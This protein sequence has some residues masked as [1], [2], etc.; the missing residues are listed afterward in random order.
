MNKV[1]VII[2]LTILGLSSL[3]FADETMTITT[4]YPSPYGSYRELTAHRMKI[5][6]IYSLPGTSVA[7][8]NLIVEGRVGINTTNLEGILNVG[9]L[10]VNNNGNDASLRVVKQ[11]DAN[12][13]TFFY[14][15]FFENQ[16]NSYFNAGVYAS[17]RGTCSGA[18]ACWAVHGDASGGVEDNYGVGVF[19]IGDL[20]PGVRAQSFRGNAIEAVGGNVIINPGNVGIGNITPGAKLVVAGGVRANKG[21]TGANDLSNV[22]YSFEQ[23]GDTGM[24]C[25]GGNAIML[26]DLIFKTDTVERMRIANSGGYVGIGTSS[27]TER[28]T[29]A[30]NVRISGT[31]ASNQ[32]VD[33]AENMAW[34]DKIQR[35]PEPG[36]VVV[37]DLQK[38]ENITLTDEPYNS[39]VAGVISTQPG[40]LL[41][42]SLKGGAV[43]LIGRVPTKVNNDN[44]AI[45]RGSLL[46]T[47]SKPGYAMRGDPEKI[48]PGM[49]IGKAMG[50]LKETDAEG[51]IPVLVN[52]N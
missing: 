4:Y 29:V 6:R 28:L 39:S 48:K 3:G 45:N 38:D 43:A 44:G 8:D 22:G 40:L 16:D 5:G 19:G 33:I 31:Y 41:G 25:V 46:V 36:D 47:S 14:T 52:S 49:L 17:Y 32:A 18:Q 34:T 35:P 2:G 26:S 23:D 27:P 50:E 12:S 10:P 15:G 20:G 42:A 13:N 21:N 1:F 9:P 37:I 7:D 11:D 24:F 30:G 51:I